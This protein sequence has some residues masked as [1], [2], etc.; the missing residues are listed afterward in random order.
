MPGPPFEIPPHVLDWIR[1]VFASVNQRSA[2]NLSRI[3]TIHETTLD[4]NLIGYLS[5]VGAPFKLS[6]DWIV[7]LDTHF[8]GGGKYWGKWEIAD[9]GILIAFRQKG[10]LLG[11]KI[12][13]LQSKRLYPD[14]IELA[15]DMHAVDYEVGFG[16]L[17]TSDSEY[18]SQ[19]KPR[20][21]HF[22]KDS[23]YRALEYKETQYEA[24]L[25]YAK[26]HGISVHYLLY[27]P[28]H[29]PSDAVIPVVAGAAQKSQNDGD[30]GCRI[31]NSATLDMKLA[32]AKL[33]KSNN[34][35]FEQIAGSLTQIDSEFWTLHN[36]VVDL[37]IACKEGYL[38]GT[39]PF[40]DEGLY[41]VFNLRAGPISAA[42]SITI[43]AP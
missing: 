37:V 1:S 41:R 6:S 20:T 2:A 40:Q 27:N 21:F 31:M 17:L 26:D 16:R 9:I 35:S 5:E 33:K 7:T 4:H 13:L 39:N 8:L 30:I 10:K 12:A 3:P 24:I 18:G 32:S 23:K 14:E 15:T 34:P 25:K 28:L 42:L 36:F 19:V 38:A 11:T 22:S 43:D 29:L